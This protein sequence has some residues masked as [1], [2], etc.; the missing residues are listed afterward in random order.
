MDEAAVAI[1]RMIS[2]EQTAIAL[3]IG[4]RKAGS[5]TAM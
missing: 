4:G 5:R 1:G 3:V 2:R